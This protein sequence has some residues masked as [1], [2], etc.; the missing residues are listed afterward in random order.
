MAWIASAPWLLLLWHDTG[1]LLPTTLAAKR[2]W[3]AEGCWDLARRART[4]G[5]GLGL[6]L[7]ISAGAAPGVVGLWRSRLG[8]L[9]L[10]CFAVTLVV[11]AFSVPSLLYAYHRH[12]YFAPYLGFLVVGLTILPGRWHRL[13]W[14]GTA[15][16][17]ATLTMVVVYEP[18]RIEQMARERAEILAM[19]ESAR[20]ERVLVHD[21]GFIPWSRRSGVFTDLVGLKTPFAA[22]S[23]RALTGPS[24]GVRRPEAV[25]AIARHGDIR[26]VLVWGVWNATFGI[27]D[28]LTT[29][30]WTVTERSRT[31]GSD[32]TI[33]FAVTPPESRAGSRL[34]APGTP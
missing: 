9:A 34:W 30:G 1:G 13:T 18:R 11:W 27:A 5:S 22:A 7:A 29:R 19:L 3:Y 2:D 25:D 8:R 17:L 32:P 28:G 20:A 23:H 14:L 15:A 26:H 16:A 10:A 6:W 4:V 12:R 24:C 31:S 21:A 33:L